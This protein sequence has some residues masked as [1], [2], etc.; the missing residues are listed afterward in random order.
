MVLIINWLVDGWVASQLVSQFF[1]VVT[2][3]AQLQ[4]QTDEL[5]L[6]KEE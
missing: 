5:T 2:P 1:L 6:I 4:T 3:L